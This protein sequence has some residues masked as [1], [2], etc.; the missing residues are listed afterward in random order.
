MSNYYYITGTSRGLGKAFTEYLLQ[1]PENRVLGISRTNTITHKNYS[2]VTLDLGRPDAVKTF[3]FAS[4]PDAKRIVLINNAGT[5]GSV[6]P[7]GK[8]DPQS[9]IDAYAINLVSPT[10]LS[11]SFIAAY[12]DIP[13]EKLIINVSSGA[14]KSPVDGWSVYCASKSGLDM[15]SRVTE[16]EQKMRA[17]KFRVLSIAPGI[18]DTQ[19]QAD[20]RKSAGEDFSRLNDFLNYKNANLLA[21][22][23]AVA[24]KYFD[25]IERLHA[26]KD[27]VISVRDF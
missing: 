24:K 13:A 2:H 8:L 22:P 18:V 16:E 17:D 3:R 5:L 23:Q 9:V 20:I 4:H 27:V 15:L 25:I 6:K 21:D 10:L 12:R 26:I 19:M 11:N 14:G 1:Q 7:L